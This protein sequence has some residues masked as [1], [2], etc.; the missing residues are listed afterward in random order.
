MKINNRDDPALYSESM[1]LLLAGIHL[2]KCDGHHHDDELHRLRELLARVIFDPE[3]Q[4]AGVLL[5]DGARLKDLIAGLGAIIRNNH[6]WLVCHLYAKLCSLVVRDGRIASPEDIE[7]NWI[8]EVLGL[9]KFEASRIM[10]EVIK[11]E[12]NPRLVGVG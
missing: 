9:S 4:I 6:S 5:G 2:V 7:I 10:L 8:A 3:D 11:L 1:F 12:F